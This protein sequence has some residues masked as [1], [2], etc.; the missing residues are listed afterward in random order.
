MRQR[1]V[2]ALAAVV[3]G[4]VLAV[5]LPGQAAYIG[6]FLVIVGGFEA[7]LAGLALARDADKAP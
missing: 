4:L 5:S 2:R 1:L 3:V 7:V 6:G